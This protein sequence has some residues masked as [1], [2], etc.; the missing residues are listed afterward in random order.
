LLYLRFPRLLKGI[1]Y[2]EKVHEAI[3]K[4]SKSVQT[5]LECELRCE[6][7]REKARQEREQAA[8]AVRQ[9]FVSEINRKR[10]EV[11]YFAHFSSAQF[12]DS[13]DCIRSLC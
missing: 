7:A 6:T 12:P 9:E 2:T 8:A 4:S 3:K 5:L 10:E 11:R 1:M 13:D